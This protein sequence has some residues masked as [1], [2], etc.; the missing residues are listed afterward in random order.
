[1]KSLGFIENQN[2]LLTEEEFIEKMQKVSHSPKAGSSSLISVKPS[3]YKRPFFYIHGADGHTIDTVLGQYIDPERPFYGIRAVGRDGQGVPH[4]C[5]EQMAAYYIQEIQTVQPEGPY[6]L[7][8]RCSGGNIALEMAQQ[9]K[10]RGHQVLLVVMVDSPKPLLTEEEKVEYPNA[11]AREQ[12][13]WRGKLINDDSDPSPIEIDFN[14]KVFEYNLQIPG[15]YIP[16]I[17]SGRVVYFAA[18]ERSKD[19]F[20]SELLQPNAWNRWVI[21]GVEV[22]EVPGDH[23]SMTKEPNV[24]V[25][26]EKLSTCLDRAECEEP[27]QEQSGEKLNYKR[28]INQELEDKGYTVIDFLQE[29]EVQSLIRFYRENSIPNDIIEPVVSATI[30]SSDLAYRQQVIQQAKKVFIPKLEILFP[31]H[32]IAIC[33]FINKKTNKL[34]SGVTR[35][36]PLLEETPGDWKSRLHKRSPPA[37]TL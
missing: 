20:I 2:R 17:Y 28:S 31:N 35:E 33:T 29:D 22:Y 8:G 19:S 23:L 12:M 5:V 10:K 37:R 32:K 4:T 3:G 36:H 13:R 15:N 1:M 34:F 16:Q 9:L 25:L 24:R 7:G 18:Q 30:C 27:K 11:I 26:A 6:L 14:P 21:N